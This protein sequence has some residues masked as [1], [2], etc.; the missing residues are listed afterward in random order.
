[1]D[2]QRLHCGMARRDEGMRVHAGPNQE[3]DP[4]Q[5]RKFG[6]CNDE[7]DHFHDG[8][9]NDNEQ[10]ESL[11]RSHWIQPQLMAAAQP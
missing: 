1:M 2:Q 4:V 6:L 9:K 3:S 10:K 7:H 11:N 8:K 5:V